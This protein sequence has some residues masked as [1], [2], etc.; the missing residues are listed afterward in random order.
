MG[1]G[2]TSILTIVLI[3][4]FGTSHLT[5][6]YKMPQPI[7]LLVL[8]FTVS[9]ILT[10]MQEQGQSAD[11]ISLTATTKLQCVTQSNLPTIIIQC[12]IFSPP[13]PVGHLYTKLLLTTTFLNHHPEQ[14]WL[15]LGE[16]QAQEVAVFFL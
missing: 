4:N 5:G 14:A 7:T 12:H 13:L 15:Q 6:C 8:T 16:P 3:L 11:R 1:K 2:F 10:R 9:T